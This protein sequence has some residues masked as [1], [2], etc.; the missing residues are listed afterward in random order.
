MICYDF[1][2]IT[3]SNLHIHCIIGHPLGLSTVQCPVLYL[4]L[5]SSLLLVIHVLSFGVC[6]HLCN[7]VYIGASTLHLL[8]FTRVVLCI[9]LSSDVHTKDFIQV[10][11]IWYYTN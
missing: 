3:Y 1:T 9:L 8:V 4:L 7:F 5:S 6:P 2:V 10:I 11:T